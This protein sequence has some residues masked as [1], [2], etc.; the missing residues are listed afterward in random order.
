MAKRSGI[1][2]MLSLISLIKPLIGLMFLAVLMGVIGNLSATFISVL[3][4]FLIV[5]VLGYP[6][7]FN[8][9]LLISLLLICALARGVLRY[10]EQ[11]CNHFIAFKLLALIRHQVF[12]ALRKLAFAKLE[13]KDKGDLLALITSDIELLEVFYAHT[14]SP[15]LIAFIFSL[16]M[17]IFIGYYHWLLAIWALFA[18]V[19]V[20]ILVPLL[21]SKF[22][23]DL[24]LKIRNLA[25]NLSSYVLDNLRG[26]SEVLQYHQNKNRLSGMDQK[27]VELLEHEERMKVVIGVNQGL[28]Q[29]L[30]W[31]F[32]LGMLVIS[33][34]LY[35][36]GLIGFNV[37]IIVTIALMSSFG[38][39]VA[40]ANL[41]TTLQNTL[42]AGNR[43]LDILE[44]K[45][46]IEEVTIGQQVDFTGVTIKNVNFA[47]DQEL[48]LR[49]INLEIKP[50][51]ILGLIGSSGSGKSTL[52]RLLMRYY[53]V[54]QGEIIYGET[55]IKNIQTTNLR[56]MISFMTQETH[57]FNDS[58]KNNLLIAKLDANDQ[59]LIGVCKQ[60]AIHD[61]IM[62]LPNGYD[63]LIGELGDKLS[64]GQRQ[65]FGLAR[66]LLHNSDLLLLDEPTSNLDS[67]NE[68][69]ILKSLVETRE[70]KTIILVSHRKSTLRI[71]DDLYYIDNGRLS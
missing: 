42:A 48:I 14:I 5:N 54:N 1:K 4:S 51:T 6:T 11:Y 17:L 22:S 47:Y 62:S 10:C 38:P 50:Q 53:D 12:K 69:L 70:N 23:K 40:L 19:I 27:T 37:V 57:L 52:L 49:D 20:G 29:G 46:V 26:I 35:W 16:V 21:M 2:V 15:I 36:F 28:I 44:E 65:R 68:A 25:G 18:Y 41:G 61:F 55:N 9:N 31:F 71:V 8:F 30:I 24:G 3:G 33:A 59:Q 13:V 67:L 66:A 64:G 32:D 43:V 60:V 58:I 45:P 7:F 34:H 39:V 63:T 56:N